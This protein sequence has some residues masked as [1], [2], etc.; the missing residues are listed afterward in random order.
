MNQ[1]TKFRFLIDGLIILLFTL[2]TAYFTNR[3]GYTALGGDG[4]AHAT[5]IKFL[6]D[7]WPNINWVYFWG[8]GIP[9]FLWYGFMPYAF[10]VSFFK[11]FSSAAM[12]ISAVNLLTFV[13]I[14]IGIYGIVYEVT[15]SRVASLLAV[16]LAIPSPGLW[17]RIMVGTTTRTFGDGF[18][19][20]SIW[21]LV[22][23]LKENP[24]TSSGQGEASFRFSTLL[25]LA[26]FTT[27]AFQ[28]HFF[29]ALLTGFFGFVI[30]MIV[31]KG[32]GQRI[33]FFFLTFFP[34]F[35][36]AFYFLVP[37]ILTQHL[38]QTASSFGIFAVDPLDLKLLFYHPPEAVVIPGGGLLPIHLPLLLVLLPI[39][40]FSGKLKDKPFVKKTIFA[41]LSLFLFFLAFGTAIYFGYP[42]TWY[43]TGFVPDEAFEFLSLVIPVMLGVLLWLV[44]SQRLLKV[45]VSVIFL[46]LV[47]LTVWQY[48]LRYPLQAQVPFEFGP[49]AVYDQ[50]LIWKLLEG[51][52][53]EKNYRYAHP[54]TEISIWFNFDSKIPQN[55]EFFPHGVMYPNWRSW[56]ENAIW[57]PKWD[58]KMGETKFL[59]DWFSL[60][61]FS[62][63]PPSYNLNIEKYRRDSDFE[64]KVASQGEVETGFEFKKA[65]PILSSTNAPAILVIG[66]RSQDRSFGPIMRI[67]ATFNFNSQVI[68]PVRGKSF[69]D[70][71][72]G[73]EL[74]KFPL[75][76]LYEY[77]IKNPSK[78]G[79][80]LLDFLNQ[81]GKVVI[82][83][84]SF[85][86][87]E[88]RM[89]FE[90]TLGFQS[91]LEEASEGKWNF[92]PSQSLLTEGVNFSAF[93]PPLFEESAW[94]Y[95][96]LKQN[97]LG[98][99]QEPILFNEGQ[100]VVFRQRIGEGELIWSGLNLPYHALS[101][102]N[103]EEERFLIKMVFDLLETKPEVLSRLKAI[104]HFVNPQLRKIE[105]LEP[106]NGILFKENYFFN[107]HAALEKDGQKQEMKI[108]PAGTDFMYIPLGK[109][110][111]SGKVTIFY[112]RSL[113]EQASTAVSLLSLV[114]LLTL[115]IGYLKVGPTKFNN[116]LINLR[117]K[118]VGRL[119]LWWQ[120]EDE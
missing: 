114:A 68:L 48:P 116:F 7:F 83:S 119:G 75:I 51:Q 94:K 82:E 96:Y 47:G 24:S 87:D 104:S 118:S 67:L 2:F 108:Y 15:K 109:S 66:E 106:A 43:D 55:R 21:F 69:L 3:A 56:Q 36:F 28:S 1:G 27:L 40:F 20:L 9:V 98:Q 102:Q 61:W 84:T 57:N 13:M 10:L 4:Y 65:T 52:E 50:N 92:S 71:Y 91:K 11:I 46:I 103:Q 23:V 60:R 79:K 63:V 41:F 44:L 16:F 111:D 72:K 54:A 85:L 97:D 110:E 35:L 25:G 113:M 31:V 64:M 99:N 17:Y 12:A 86:S 32:W 95:R 93:S 33:K 30:I 105:I 53:N 45:F 89:I 81:G 18:L 29:T 115:G 62:L 90:K 8:N 49:R 70:D 76:F 88:R 117:K 38:S 77:R 26:L 5:K 112:K 73:E 120:K 14:G 34:A 58:E 37:F 78:A 80:I 42:A 100:V 39:V 6:V 107:W 19:V 74:A 22:R 59:L 101:Y